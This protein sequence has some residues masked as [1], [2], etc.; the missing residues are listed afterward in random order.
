MLG[1]GDTK[2]NIACHI[3]VVGTNG[4]LIDVV[5]CCAVEHAASKF[6][7]DSLPF[8][9]AH[10]VFELVDG[11]GLG[12]AQIAVE[13]FVLLLLTDT[14]QFYTVSVVFQ[15]HGE[16]VGVQLLLNGIGHH[17]T[18]R[19][20]GY[21]NL[22]LDFL[23]VLV[24]A[25]RDFRHIDFVAYM[26]VDVLSMIGGKAAPQVEAWRECQRKGVARLKLLTFLN[27]THRGNEIGG[28]ITDFCCFD[29]HR[30]LSCGVVRRNTRDEHGRHHSQHR[31]HH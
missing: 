29:A 17:H 15:S 5:Y 24:F 2:G 27:A 30:T 14:K 21:R 31:H 26:H 13:V 28:K 12:N 9:V 25:Q 6:L 7:G 18:E 8:A 19:F 3:L 4:D 1:A 11:V 22:H 10:L 20:V 23:Q 16:S